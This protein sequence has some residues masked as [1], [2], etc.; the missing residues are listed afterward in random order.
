MDVTGM[1]RRPPYTAAEGPPIIPQMDQMWILIDNATGLHV[2]WYFWLRVLDEA[3]R[4]TRY[5][6]PFGLLLLEGR[7]DGAGG[8]SERQ[9]VDAAATVP[10]AIRS[11]DLGGFVTPGRVAVLLTHQTAESAQQARDRILERMT[12][13]GGS[14]AVRWSAR[15]LTY[16]EDAAEISQLLTTGWGAGEAGGREAGFQRSA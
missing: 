5:G 11:T 1:G 10:Q 9:L 15:L 2:G 14:A 6:T 7:A 12:A 8:K 3:N 13:A 4:S 16:P